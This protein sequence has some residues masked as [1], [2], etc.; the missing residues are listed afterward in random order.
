VKSA[1]LSN[2]VDTR[3]LDGVRAFIGELKD[4]GV[5]KPFTDVADFEHNVVLD[6]HEEA[7]RLNDGERAV[8]QSPPLEDGMREDEPQPEIAA[9]DGETVDIV[10]LRL[11]LE[12]KLTWLCK[13]LLAVDGVPTFATVG[14]LQ[15]DGYLKA[16][17]ARIA[18]RVLALDAGRSAAE[19]ATFLD[20]AERVVAMFRAIVFDAHVRKALRA[21]GWTIRDWEQPPGHRPDVLAQSDGRTFRIAPRLATSNESSIVAACVKRLSRSRDEP[22]PAQRRIVVVPDTSQAPQDG[23]DADPRV[24][25]LAALPRAL[26]EG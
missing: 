18:T 14:S 8:E 15:Y 24:V 19:R 16:E 13:Q 22:E 25:R 21:D 5:V 26:V 20:D 1:P 12:R 10:A 9:V 3:Q 2:D 6:L 17:Q 11:K 7:K 4:A 23:P